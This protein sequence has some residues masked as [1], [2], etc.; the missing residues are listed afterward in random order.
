MFTCPTNKCFS[1]HEPISCVHTSGSRAGADH[2]LVELPDLEL[3]AEEKRSRAVREMWANYH[4][5]RRREKR[6]DWELERIRNFAR[7]QTFHHDS[8]GGGLTRLVAYRSDLPADIRHLP[9]S[10]SYR[11]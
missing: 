11:S 9:I 8:I 4:E 6:Q 5:R 10:R 7:P 2:I 3:S 1:N